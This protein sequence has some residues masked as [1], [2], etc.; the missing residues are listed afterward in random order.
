L[1]A[2][3][4]GSKDV[5]DVSLIKFTSLMRSEA[6]H[7]D[8][9]RSI[10]QVGALCGN[11]RVFDWF[12]KRFTTSESEHDRMNILVALGCFREK[13]L[14]ERALQYVLD[15]VPRRNKFVPLVAM[16]SNPHASPYMWDWY[17][18]NLNALEQFHPL[19]YERVI[20]GIIPVCGLGKEDEV[21]AFFEQY[22][23]R[24]KMAQ[25]SIKLSLEKLKIHCRMRNSPTSNT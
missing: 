14:I 15:K 3:L 12:A 20:A 9:L 18:S 11:D 22:I 6:I 7:P 5:E 2:A 13:K 8:I 21:K 23:K 1:H 19:H 4:Y 24:K 17:K 25:D 16:A 10:M